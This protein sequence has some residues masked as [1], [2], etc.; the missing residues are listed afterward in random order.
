MINDEI[1]NLTQKFNAARKLNNRFLQKINGD[2]DEL[3]GCKFWVDVEG[4]ELA[5]IL[6]KIHFAAE[7]S[8]VLEGNDF[9]IEYIFKGVRNEQKIEVFRFYL[10]GGVI[11]LS[12]N[13]N[14]EGIG[15]HTLE[16][17]IESI[18]KNFCSSLFN[19][20]YFSASP[21]E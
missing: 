6:D 11:F 17:T 8:V 4:E 3:F 16:D 21:Q 7:W 9:A 14:D 20:K 10:K 18:F 19:S 12:I 15:N 2:Q 5:I 1:V 13:Q